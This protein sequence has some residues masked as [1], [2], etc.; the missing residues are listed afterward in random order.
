MKIIIRLIKK[1]LKWFFIALLATMALYII[2]FQIEN[3][4]YLNK[5]ANT[6]IGTFILDL[7]RT[8]LGKYSD[9]INEYK[10]LTLEFKRDKTFRI[11][12]SVPFIAD[13]AGIWK[14][15]GMEEW[16]YIYYNNWKDKYDK[17]IPGDQ[18]TEGYLNN[19]DSIFYINSVTPRSDQFRNSDVHVV[20]FKDKE[21]R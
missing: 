16:A 5:K 6:L 10:N 2:Y 13:T 17:G 15:G 7:E 11:N 4:K 19:G 21:I 20:Y 12:K 18:I 14:V 3:H 9:S 1:I 8:N